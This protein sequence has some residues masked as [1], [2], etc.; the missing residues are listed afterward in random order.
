MLTGCGGGGNS[1]RQL[2]H[3]GHTPY[4][5]DTILVTYATNPERALMLLDSTLL[6]GN[7]SDYRGQVIR[8][9]I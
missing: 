1:V 3:L 9:K 7:I 4:Q 2:Q 8:A 5:E 6:L